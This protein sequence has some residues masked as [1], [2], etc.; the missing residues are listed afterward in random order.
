MTRTAE[1]HPDRP[2]R[3]HGLCCACWERERRRKRKAERLGESRPCRVCG[4]PFPPFRGDSA[5]CSTVCQRVGFSRRQSRRLGMDIEGEEFHATRD[6][7]LAEK[8]LAGYLD[9]G[10]QRVGSR[11]GGVDAPYVAA[12]HRGEGLFLIRARLPEEFMEEAA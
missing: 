3:G 8:L 9:R 7:Q 2:V 12:W 4:T 5:Y 11:A 10:C 1:C 6:R